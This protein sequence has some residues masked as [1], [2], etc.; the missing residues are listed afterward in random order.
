MQYGL[1]IK[2]QLLFNSL[3]Q[4]TRL[5]ILLFNLYYLEIRATDPVFDKDP[6]GEKSKS[7]SSCK[8]RAA[9]KTLPVTPAGTPADVL[10]LY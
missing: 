1:K 4:A 8:G 10:T 6:T 3:L 5:H 9:D 2:I 7:K